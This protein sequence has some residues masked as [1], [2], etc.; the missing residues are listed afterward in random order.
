MGYGIIRPIYQT[1]LIENVDKT[2]HWEVLW[3]T[4]SM[5]SLVMFLWPLFAG[6]LMDKNI[7]IFFASSL[8]VFISILFLVKLKDYL[9]VKK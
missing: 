9:V 4:S 7:D 3:I 6:Y 1:E 8:F 2:Q 5:Q